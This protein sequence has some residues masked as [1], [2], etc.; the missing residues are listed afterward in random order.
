MVCLHKHLKINIMG[1]TIKDVFERISDYNGDLQ[2]DLGHFTKKGKRKLKDQFGKLYND[3]S[4]IVYNDDDILN[5]REYFSVADA[6]KYWGKS[7]QTVYK[8]IKSG[9]IRVV[10]DKDGET[11]RIPKKELTGYFKLMDKSYSTLVICRNEHELKDENNNV[12]YSFKSL[13]Y[14]LVYSGEFIVTLFDLKNE[15]KLIISAEHYKKQFR[16][17]NY[18]EKVAYDNNM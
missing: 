15:N 5:G 7:T 14:N 11:I 18:I 3:I 16:I 2:K 6:A 10:K 13:Y 9:K 1:T 12:I 8:E 17:A 4:I